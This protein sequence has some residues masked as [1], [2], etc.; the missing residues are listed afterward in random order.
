[1]EIIRDTKIGPRNLPAFKRVGLNSWERVVF[2]RQLAWADRSGSVV[3]NDQGR[4]L[5]GKAAFPKSGFFL[6]GGVPIVTNSA[7]VVSLNERSYFSLLD[8]HP[9]IWGPCLSVLPI[10]SSRSFTPR[11]MWVHQIENGDE[12]LNAEPNKAIFEPT[13]RVIPEKISLMLKK[14]L[15][16]RTDRSLYCTLQERLSV[17]LEK[18]FSLNATRYPLGYEIGPVEIRIGD[19]LSED[20]SVSQVAQLILYPHK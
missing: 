6:H 10:E 20:G 15:A 19:L 4:V 13:L 14:I 9:E 5:D 12:V 17:R 2:G 1:M 18:G 16:R 11:R 8:N 7:K 3:V